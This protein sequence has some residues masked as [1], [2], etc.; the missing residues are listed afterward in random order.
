MAWQASRDAGTGVELNL[1]NIGYQLCWN[2]EALHLHLRLQP[3]LRQ[4]AVL[5]RLGSFQTQFRASGCADAA[6]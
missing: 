5:K 2:K 6:V 1:C 4:T 3:C